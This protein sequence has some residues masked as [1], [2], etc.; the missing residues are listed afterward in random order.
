MMKGLSL[1]RL[2]WAAGDGLA[3]P[4][5]RSGKGLNACSALNDNRSRLNLMED[6]QMA[7]QANTAIAQQEAP[8][9]TWHGR[10]SLEEREAMIREA[11]YFRYERRGYVHGNDLD[12]W[13]AA[14]HEIGFGRSRRPM[15][16]APEQEVQQSSV[17]GAAA[18]ETLKH[19]VR[20]HPQKAISLVESVEPKA[21]PRKE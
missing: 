3:S 1:E 11:A 6:E 20:Q 15:P 19:I 10:F 12:D 17:H 2:P 21:S 14:E 7:R 9:V 13:L 16:D 5:S 8:G 4:V 18:D